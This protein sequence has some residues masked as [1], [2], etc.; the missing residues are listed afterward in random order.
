MDG[1][2]LKVMEDHFNHITFDAKLAKAIYRYQVGFINE[3]REHME[4]FGSN[5]LGVHV[6]RYKSSRVNMLYNDILAVDYETL[7]SDLYSL[8]I[9]EPSH[10]IA[11]D[12]FNL[13]IMYMVFKF[14]NAPRLSAS[15][16][17]RAAYDTALLFFYRTM[18]AIQNSYFPYPTDPKIAQAAYANL[19]N[20][21]L[22]KQLGSWHKV[23]D[24]RANALLDKKSPHAKTFKTFTSDL[25][26]LYSIADSQG[27]IRDLVK[28]Y[29]AE[30]YKVHEDGSSIGS[31][32]TTSKDADGEKT[33]RDSIKAPEQMVFFM[34]STILDRRSFIKEDLIRVIRNINTNTSIRMVRDTLTWLSD[35]YQTRQHSKLIDEFVSSTI[36]YSAFLI[37]NN[38]D[39]P[40]SRDYPFI[41]GN[42]KNLY[43]STRSTDPDLLR[44]RQLGDEVILKSSGKTSP[45][46]GMATR[47]STILYLSLRALVGDVS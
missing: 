27:R 15:N 3:T 46:L 18:S 41:L 30:F 35:N 45:S 5:L 6:L 13:T 32:S 47:T 9:I 26:I 19:S 11:S 2:I 14:L 39:A 40:N 17:T 4:F 23:M 25:D 22:I 36:M 16:R 31:T 20:K 42:L 1:T 21:Y 29:C 44:I 24:Y 8:R 10:K 28:N 37:E 34:R 43:L 7:K 12:V 33:I 38:I